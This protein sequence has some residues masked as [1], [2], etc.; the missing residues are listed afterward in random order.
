MTAGTLFDNSLTRYL[1]SALQQERV[2]RIINEELT[3]Q[4][5]YVLLA[6]YFRDL[7]MP[8]IAAERGIHKSTV[9]RTLHRAEEKIRRCLQ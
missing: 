9:C 8:Q 5:R 7:T 2:H 1:P 3:P 6:Y 4:Q